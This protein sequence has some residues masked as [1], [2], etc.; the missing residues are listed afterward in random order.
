MGR[1]RQR[2]KSALRAR[3]QSG[4][5]CAQTPNAA[6]DNASVPTAKHGGRLVRRDA[7]ARRHQPCIDGRW[8][9]A[10]VIDIRARAVRHIGP[11]NRA[12]RACSCVLPPSIAAWRAPHPWQITDI[13]TT[14][15]HFKGLAYR[16]VNRGEPNHQC[17]LL[18][19]IDH[20][21]APATL[22]SNPCSSYPA[23]V[24]STPNRWRKTVTA[25]PT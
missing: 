12:K 8:Q 2:P 11:S 7:G 23:G 17:P 14:P 6:T 19:I 3:P 15:A 20:S 13:F 1:N 24:P 4:A 25:I 10:V 16:G 22:S 5:S 21:K 9:R 18:A